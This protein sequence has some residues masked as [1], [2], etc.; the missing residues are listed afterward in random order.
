MDSDKFAVFLLSDFELFQIDKGN[1]SIR[2]YY[3]LIKHI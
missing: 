1:V 3:E 2:L